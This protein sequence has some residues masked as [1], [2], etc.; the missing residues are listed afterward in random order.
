MPQIHHSPPPA[1]LTAAPKPPANPLPTNPAQLDPAPAV[2]LAA[3]FEKNSVY[4]CKAL[5][6]RNQGKVLAINARN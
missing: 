2:P 5:H 4:I 3:L 6:G 1:P